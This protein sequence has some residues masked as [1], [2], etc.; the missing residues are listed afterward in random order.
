[1]EYV[2]SR[3]ALSPL[4]LQQTG[5][6]MRPVDRILASAYGTQ[7]ERMLLAATLLTS[8]RQT[9]KVYPVYPAS[10]IRQAGE[11][12]GLASMTGIALEPQQ[13]AATLTVNEKSAIA[14]TRKDAQHALYT[15]SAPKGGI[16]SFRLGTL[17]TQRV[18]PLELPRPVDETY[19][20]TISC[21]DGVKLDAPNREKHLANAVGSVDIVYQWKG[22]SLV[23]TRSLKINQHVIPAAQYAEFRAL[24]NLWNTPSWQQVIVL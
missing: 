12:L 20:Y 14:L 1:M 18:S 11:A 6:R 17:N 3:L 23:I 22:Q 24:M 16:A 8:M 5:Y 10:A 19:E 9:V 7:A 15:L 13:E 21:D 2:N 4:T